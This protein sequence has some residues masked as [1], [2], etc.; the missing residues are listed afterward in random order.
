M[1]QRF[2]LASKTIQQKI[3]RKLKMLR[4]SKMSQCLL[5]KIQRLISRK[6]KTTHWIHRKMPPLTRLRIL[7]WMPQNP[8]TSR[9]PKLFKMRPLK[10]IKLF[11][12]PNRNSIAL[13][14]W[15]WTF[16]KTSQVIPAKMLPKLWTRLKTWR[17]MKL[18]IRRK[19]QPKLHRPKNDNF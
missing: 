7:R 12:F 8:K 13:P 14:I 5:S 19:M 11:I 10:P 15:L 9:Q 3:N 2:Q 16:P 6:N 18:V 17:K 1:Q 4:F